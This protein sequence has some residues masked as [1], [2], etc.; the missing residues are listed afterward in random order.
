MN[1]VRRVWKA[2][3][4]KSARDFIAANIRTPIREF[5]FALFRELP[6]KKRM[7]AW[8]NS[9]EGRQYWAERG[10]GTTLMS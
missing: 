7:L 6:A 8:L 3:L 10:R 5:F 2:V 4:P 9:A 1:I